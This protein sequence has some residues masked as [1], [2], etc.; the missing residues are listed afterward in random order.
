[1]QS[2]ELDYGLGKMSVELPNSAVVVRYGKTYTDPPVV[3][4]LTHTRE[5][6]DKP[7][8]MPP[9]SELAGA[10]KTAAIVFPDRVKGGA[11]ALAHRRVVIPMILNDLLAGGCLLQDI[12]LVC[13]QGLHRRNTYA[14][15]L[16]YLGPEIVDN[17]WPSRIFNHDAEGADVLDLGP[18]DMGNAVET[19]GR[20]AAVDIPVLIGHCAGNPYGGY[21][22]GYKMLVTGLAGRR[23][24]ASHHVPKT[25]HRSDWLGGAR[26]SHMRDQFQSIGETIESRTGKAFFAVD[27]VLGQKA[28]TL[29]VQA[30]RI[31]AV[32]QATWPLAD[33]RTNI[34]LDELPEP[35]DILLV[36]MPRDFHYGPGMGTNPILMGLGIGVQFSRCAK[37]LRPGAV[38][39]A[40]AW[41]DGWFNADWFPSYA[42]TYDA[43][44]G[45]AT[46]KAFLNS[47]EAE[48][49]SSDSEY[50]YSYSNRYTYHPFHAM[51]MTS[52][53]SVPLK[54]CAEVMVVGARK[55][56]FARGMGYSTY[57]SVDEALK[58][59]RK[60]VGKN[61]RIL[62]TPE[63]YSGGVAVNVT[64]KANA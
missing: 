21:S 51:S 10:G 26:H 62:A 60:H 42:E 47:A 16:W 28:G 55:P 6:L 32:E 3:D 22:G 56:G 39:I 52:G 43:L 57:T 61:P 25:M 48:R 24:I 17:F 29:D 64:C 45:F 15:W 19:N 49:I 5:A 44:Q 46:A 38:V 13:A 11:H 8:G 1:M 33:R 4:P 50:C 20:V 30:G 53:G 36:G 9:L 34:V 7:L 59:A 12:I 23:S 41:C 40:V 14:E 27:A 63:C 31:A 54:W 37:A 35:A 58:A 2:L 18:D